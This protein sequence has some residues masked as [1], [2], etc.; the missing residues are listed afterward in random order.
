[1]LELRTFGGLSLCDE[2][3]RPLG[4]PAAQRSRLALLAVVAASGDRGVSRDRLQALFWPESDATRARG[5]LNQAVYSLRREAGELTVGTTELRLNPAVLTSDVR[6]FE[7]AL[8]AGRT[9]AAVATYAGPFLDGVHLRR[10]PE[11]EN[12]LEDERRRLERK[13][14]DALEQLARSARSAGDHEGAARWWRSLAKADPLSGRIALALIDGLVETGDREAAIR[15]GEMYAARVRA[16]LD[17][18]PDPEVAERIRR[19][20]V[21]PRPAPS[22]PPHRVEPRVEPTPVVPGSEIVADAPRRRSRMRSVGLVAFV[23]LTLIGLVSWATRLPRTSGSIPDGPADTTVVVFPFRVEGDTSHAYLGS[24]M[25][26]LL[27]QAVDGSARL[28]G[29]D[30]RAVQSLLNGGEPPDDAAAAV[31]LAARLGGELFVLGTVFVS[32]GNMRVSGELYESRRSGTPIAT[33]SAEGTAADPLSTIDDFA[34]RLLAARWPAQ[35]RPL[36]QAAALT[37]KLPALKAFLD[38]EHALRQGD[39]QRAVAGYTRA[40]H[41]DSAFA[42]AYLRLA[43]VSTFNGM[44]PRA[45]TLLE[46]AQ[47]FVHTLPTRYRSA[48]DAMTASE[49][50]D[51]HADR[52]LL[53]HV[54]QYPDDADGW[55]AL[56]DW[57]LHEN[58]HRGEPLA[59]AESAIDRAIALDSAHKPA[60]IHH[61][62]LKMRRGKYDEAARDLRFTVMPNRLELTWWI[63]AHIEAGRPTWMADITARLDTL[64]VEARRL[65]LIYAISLTNNARPGAR[66]WRWHLQH[67][68]V[69]ATRLNGMQ[70]LIWMDVLNGE[71]EQ[72]WADLRAL[73]QQDAEGR[74]LIRVLLS[75]LPW[76]AADSA[77]LAAS[78]TRY[79]AW[80]PATMFPGDDRAALDAAHRT[81]DFLAAIIHHRLKDEAGV[82]G[83]IARLR[84]SDEDSASD[85]L[86][87]ELATVLEAW[88]ATERGDLDRARAHLAGFTPGPIR[89]GMVD[90]GYLERYLLAETLERLGDHFNARRWYRALLEDYTTFKTV[91]FRVPALLGEAR[92]LVAFGQHEDARERYA[93]AARLWSEGDPSSRAVAADARRSAG[94]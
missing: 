86:G 63:V 29:A 61:F 24:A 39:M 91:A 78:L 70:A 28:R 37:A 77:E 45:D 38:A 7:E 30:A 4:G 53:L 60:L 90:A 66:L 41:E 55:Y 15:H 93:R 36:T 54:R 58:P 1:M 20:R 12:W 14:Q 34:G 65:G 84:S 72:A 3:G 59:D 56:G 33:A 81:R 64:S 89:G 22:S 92:A 6:R 76:V 5:A 62:E 13:Y 32:G 10:L 21:E 51:P 9:E 85:A 52:K 87:R 68:D 40:I 27:G 17:I 11:L 46:Q 23:V 18:E 79:D 42:L 75:V 43:T 57:L 94:R 47:R 31:P 82:D 83:R 73:E 48:L 26:E 74:L 19:L 8:A 2:A 35:Q 25:V 44:V 80:D 88:V 69:R 16:E 71:A 49:T 67:A 50:G